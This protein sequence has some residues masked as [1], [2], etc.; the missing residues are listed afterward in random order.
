MSKELLF[1]LKGVLSRKFCEYFPVPDAVRLLLGIGTSAM[2][3]ADIGSI[4][5]I[6]MMFGHPAAFV[7][8]GLKASTFVPF[9]PGTVATPAAD[10]AT[11]W[12]R[13]VPQLLAAG[14]AEVKQSAVSPEYGLKM[15]GS[16]GSLKSPLRSA[17]VGTLSR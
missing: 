16:A 8:A 3:L 5:A 2:I 17:A 11:N 13:P 4:K 12:A 9:G 15:A 7:Q 14:G 6:G 1:W 10:V